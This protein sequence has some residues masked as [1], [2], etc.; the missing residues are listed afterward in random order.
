M[1]RH[2]PLSPVGVALPVLP[3]SDDGT[4]HGG[5]A[6]ISDV[7]V[8]R[9][10]ATLAE[11]VAPLVASEAHVAVQARG[12]FLLALSGGSTPAALYQLLAGPFGDHLPW[13]ATH[14]LWGDERCVPPD[15][16]RSN[17]AAV[18]RSG[19]LKR[20]LAG[21]HRMRG[22]D[23]PDAAAL[24]YEAELGGLENSESRHSA[25]HAGPPALVVDL[26]LLGLGPD[27]HTASLFPGSPALFEVGR[28]VVATEEH[29]GVP[30]LTLTLPMLRS[31]RRI[32]FLVAGAEKREAVHRVLSVRDR[33]LPATLVGESAGHV[34]WVMDEAAAGGGRPR[35]C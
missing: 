27:G 3:E 5:P 7:T 16:E 12:R 13:E 9:D 31:A 18:K 10:A 6:A 8:V 32:L 22:E 35:R 23:L 26:A 24:A 34:G 14:L 21:V 11:T 20:A 15:D 17:F 1:P 25:A 4:A 30:R 19:M 29:G 33:A 28:S 2:S